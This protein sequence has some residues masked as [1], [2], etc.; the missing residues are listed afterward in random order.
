MLY[1]CWSHL[2]PGAHK[3]FE[4]RVSVSFPAPNHVQCAGR[5]CSK[6]RNP[7]G[8]PKDNWQHFH[9]PWKRQ[10]G[11]LTPTPCGPRHPV[12]ICSV[13]ISIIAPFY[14]E[15]VDLRLV[16]L[17][18]GLTAEEV[19]KQNSRSCSCLEGFTL[20]FTVPPTSGCVGAGALSH[21]HQGPTLW[22]ALG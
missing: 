20:G 21:I 1:F 14:C 19:Q 17:L 15:E 10:K 3:N 16:G 11:C 12:F 4:G 22:G 18:E 8:L 2:P 5:L 6:G 7:I 13:V 9:A